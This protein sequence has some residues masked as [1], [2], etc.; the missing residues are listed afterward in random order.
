MVLKRVL[1]WFTGKEALKQTFS[2]HE[3]FFN[4]SQII[5]L[6]IK[7]SNSVVVICYSVVLYCSNDWSKYL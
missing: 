4:S 1:F 7:Y 3:F 6:L 5:E 2:K